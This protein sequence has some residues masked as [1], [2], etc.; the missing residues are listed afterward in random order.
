MYSIN[1]T[2][3]SI[4]KEERELEFYKD[5]FDLIILSNKKCQVSL[6]EQIQQMTPVYQEFFQ[7]SFI[8][9]NLCFDDC[10]WYVFLYCQLVSKMELAESGDEIS[11]IHTWFKK[12][13]TNKKY[14]L[15]KKLEKAYGSHNKADLIYAYAMTAEIGKNIDNVANEK[16]EDIAVWAGSAKTLLTDFAFFGGLSAKKQVD[17]FLSDFTIFLCEYIT[18]RWFKRMD[19]Y[20]THIGFD[21]ID[22]LFAFNGRRKDMEL[23]YEV[24]DD[25][26]TVFGS[27]EF[28]PEG[29]EERELATL[30]TIV[31]EIKGNFKNE[32]M[33]LSEEEKRLYAFNIVNNQGWKVSTAPFQPE[34]SDILTFLYNHIRLDTFSGASIKFYLGELY[35][36]V[37][38]NHA[39]SSKEQ[40]ERLITRLVA[41]G[42][43][44]VHFSEESGRPT[45]V[46]SFFE[47]VINRNEDNIALTECMAYPSQS[48]ISR[49][50]AKKDQVVLTSMYQDLPTPKHRLFFIVLQSIRLKNIGNEPFV[51]AVS[52]KYFS[53]S[54]QMMNLSDSELR[55]ELIPYFEWFS[56]HNIV[57]SDYSGLERRSSVIKMKFVPLSDIEKVIY[58]S[59]ISNLSSLTGVKNDL[60][61]MTG[62]VDDLQ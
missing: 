36:F 40:Y 52:Y 32:V 8:P 16:L 37:Y 31:G 15:Y 17:F 53:S 1:H 12:Q 34:D 50:Q 7:H 4:L 11:N 59:S 35:R 22:S 38:K 62:G 54:F 57:I 42:E 24:T 46:L 48:T 58:D 61:E 3:Y 19:G 29:D 20:T 5:R 43:R 47:I 39:H 23:Q 55:K 45:G 49:A 60:L 10:L 28:L 56:E 27:H 51:G 21:P 30:Q 2:A 18:K 33:E 6:C 44:K 25:T 41:I 13:K 14:Y 26:I 9:Q